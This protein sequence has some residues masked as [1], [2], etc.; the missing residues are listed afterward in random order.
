M[1]E[2][3]C[4]KCKK[5]IDHFLQV[6]HPCDCGGKFEYI[7]KPVTCKHFPSIN[8]NAPLEKEFVPVRD[9]MG[10]VW[11]WRRKARKRLLGKKGFKF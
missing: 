7:Y 6:T 8:T 4:K 9:Y 11:Y 5:R 10:D 2:Y 1:Y 3:R